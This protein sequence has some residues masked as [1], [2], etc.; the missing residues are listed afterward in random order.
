MNRR[1]TIPG[2]VYIV[3]A[4]PGDPELLTLHAARLLR[5]ADVVLHDDLIP[6]GVLELV[7]ASARVQ[8]VGKRCRRAV[9]TQEGIAKR[10]IYYALQGLAVMQLKGGDPL[11]FGRAGEEMDALREAG[12]EFEIVPGI[13]AAFAAAAAAKIPLTDRR[14]ASRLL[15]VT[16]HHSR[17]KDGI[18]W[19][20]LTTADTTLVVYMPGDDASRHVAELLDSG[21]GPETPCLLVSR[22]GL[23]G[24][25]MVRTTLFEMGHLPKLPAPSLLILGEVA[26]AR[27]APA[28]AAIILA[29]LPGD[30]TAKLDPKSASVF[31]IRLGESED[32]V[33]STQKAGSR[34]RLQSKD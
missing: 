2:K 14:L 16:N 15:L 23:A 12:I 1:F 11:I 33:S 29:E 13:T 25:Q 21:L 34:L 31:E 18:G 27:D 7:P 20:D 19:G 26:E 8:N 22:A 28:A 6:P 10:L 17:Q 3:G 5:S 9:I 24:Q 32:A 4:G 30:L